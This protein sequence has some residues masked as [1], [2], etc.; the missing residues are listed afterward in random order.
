MSYGRERRRRVLEL[1]RMTAT[2]IL[3]I[4]YL[5]QPLDLE[6]AHQGVSS[7]VEV[8]EKDEQA[9]KRSKLVATWLTSFPLEWHV[10]PLKS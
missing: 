4:T 5:Q 1:V 2:H 8:L 7:L 6:S 3:L 10:R 9:P